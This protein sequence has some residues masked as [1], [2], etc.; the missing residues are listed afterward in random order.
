MYLIC[1]SKSNARYLGKLSVSSRLSFDKKLT[2]VELHVYRDW[3]RL[4][5]FQHTC[6][7][8][9]R[10]ARLDV[11]PL[12]AMVLRFRAS[13]TS[14]IF[15]HACHWFHVLSLLALISCFPAPGTSLHVSVPALFP[16]IVLVSCLPALGIGFVF[17][18]LSSSCMCFL[19]GPDWLISLITFVVIGQM[20]LICP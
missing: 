17:P 5:I 6:L 13:G 15:S 7:V 16:R 1:F 9:P 11:L 8:F 10:F 19:L 20:W 2:C 12:L 3:P 4:H 18:A 14:C